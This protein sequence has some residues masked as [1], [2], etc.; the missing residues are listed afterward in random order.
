MAFHINSVKDYFIENLSFYKAS[1]TNDSKSFNCPKE[2]LS[3]VI[4]FTEY[5][6]C[7]S[8]L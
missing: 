6:L 8:K 3:N 1:H 4:V 7:Q 2:C 5:L